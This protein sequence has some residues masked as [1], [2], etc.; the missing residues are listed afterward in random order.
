MVKNK[1]IDFFFFKR[2]ACDENEKN[3]STSSNIKKLHQN[4]KIEKN[5]K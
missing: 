5:E 3:T 1:K 2:K 4:P